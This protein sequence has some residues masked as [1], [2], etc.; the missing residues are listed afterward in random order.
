MDAK[1]SI[2]GFFSIRERKGESPYSKSRLSSAFN[3]YT[4]LPLSSSRSCLRDL[5]S[6]LRSPESHQIYNLLVRQFTFQST[7]TFKHYSRRPTR[8]GH[9]T[10]IQIPPPS[11]RRSPTFP[12]DHI[13]QRRVHLYRASSISTLKRT[14]RGRQRSLSGPGDV[15]KHGFDQRLAHFRACSCSRSRYTVF[16]I[17]HD[18][19]ITVSFLISIRELS[20]TESNP[21]RPAMTSPINPLPCT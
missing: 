12:S 17:Q 5:W 15:P 9:F 14:S 4:I 21:A 18:L 8:S 6:S 10:V 13:R 3:Q 16:V 7:R 19:Q 1:H 20:P 11:P 2:K